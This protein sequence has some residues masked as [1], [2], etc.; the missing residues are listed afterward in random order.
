MKILHNGETY[1]LNFVS[2]FEPSLDLGS[3]YALSKVARFMGNKFARL[4]HELALKEAIGKKENPK[5]HPDAPTSRLSQV[6]VT[7]AKLDREIK[8]A[9]GSVSYEAIASA[10]TVQFIGDQDNKL[11]GKSIALG[12]LLKV[13]KL[14]D[15][16]IDLAKKE[17]QATFRKKK[18]STEKPVEKVLVEKEA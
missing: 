17:F 9:D 15:E 3:Q 16:F 18:K 1:H 4:V 14:G 10:S 11:V 7:E 5:A 12:R 2:T 6:R 8:G 13:V